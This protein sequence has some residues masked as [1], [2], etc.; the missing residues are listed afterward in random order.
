MRR[1]RVGD[2]VLVVNGCAVGY[3]GTVMSE[4]KLEYWDWRVEF[5][6]P[7]PGFNGLG[8]PAKGRYVN[9]R[10][11]ELRPIRPDAD[12]VETETEREVTA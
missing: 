1:C 4:S 3:V 7:A 12:P 6:R 9:C 2:V 5:P 11:D 10:D 8:E